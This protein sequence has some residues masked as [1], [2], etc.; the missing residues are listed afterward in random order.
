MK[1]HIMHAIGKTMYTGKVFNESE[2]SAMA[3]V[4]PRLEYE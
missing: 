1:T 4:H 2:S 3:T